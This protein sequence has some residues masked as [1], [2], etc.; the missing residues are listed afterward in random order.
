MIDML[1]EEKSARSVKI[2]AFRYAL[3]S[4]KYVFQCNNCDICDIQ[5]FKL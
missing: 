4:I 1:P 2:R 3:H 5:L